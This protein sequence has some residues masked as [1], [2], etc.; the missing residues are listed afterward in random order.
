VPWATAA[1]TLVI[2]PIVSDEGVGEAVVLGL[3]IVKSL[4]QMMGG[5]VT[6]SST[7]GHGSRFTVLLPVGGNPA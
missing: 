5:T 6:L 4:V 2:M 3:Y 1:G 7:P